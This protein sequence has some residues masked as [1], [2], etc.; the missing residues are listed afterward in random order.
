MNPAEIEAVLQVAFIQCEAVLC[1]LTEQ[2]KQ[3]LLQVLTESLTRESLSSSANGKQD[4]ETSNPLDE[5]TPEQRQALLQ[6]V[7]AQEQQDTPWKIRLLND[8]L[9]NRDSGAVQFIR[10]RYGP[11]WLN[12]IKPVHLTQYLEA[13]T[14]LDGLKLKVGDR[15]EVSNGL[16]EWVQENGPCSR[17]WF[18]CTVIGLSQGSDRDRLYYNCVIRFENGTEYEI[19]GIYQWNRYNWRWAS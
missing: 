16:W 1:P 2:Q 19:Q 15:I 3:I 4:N 5:L 9:H 7:K 18:P 12:R 8:W 14:S 10:D 6:F 11:Q 17:E 13:E